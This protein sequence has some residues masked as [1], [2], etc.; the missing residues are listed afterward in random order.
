MASQFS[1]LFVNHNLI[2]IIGHLLLGFVVVG[3]GLSAL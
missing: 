2:P 3:L 1:D